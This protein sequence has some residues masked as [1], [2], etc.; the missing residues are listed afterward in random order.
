MNQKLLILD[1]DETLIYSSEMLLEDEPDFRIGIFYTYKR[2]Y[3]NEFLEFCFENF[4][5]AVWTSSTRTYAKEILR[6]ILNENQKLKFLYSRE[7]CTFSFDEELL[8]NF[9]SKKLTKLRR[10]GVNLESV[11]VI[12]DSP[13][14]WRDSYGNLVR[15]KKFLGETD[16][17]ELSLLI[18]YLSKLKN[19]ENIRRIEKRDWKN[20]I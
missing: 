14:Q 18:K 10:R 19:A 8:E 4:E 11:I 20:M 13:E 6:N 15:V 16:D 17:K 9:Y 2:P 3:L 12:D 7:R 5:V 1:L